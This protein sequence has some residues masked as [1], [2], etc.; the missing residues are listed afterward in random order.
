MIYAS[1]Y[2]KVRLGKNNDGGYV[3]ALLPGGY[4][5][6]LSGGISNDISFET[7]I[8][9][10]YPELT[11]VAFDGTIANIPIPEQLADRLTFVR[12]NLS[13]INSEQ[14]TNLDTYLAQYNNI[15]MK[16]D[17]EGGEYPLLNSIA[18]LANIKQL[19]IEF[20]NIKKSRA[21]MRRLSQ[22]HYLIHLHPNNSLDYK[23][24][25]G[26]KVPKVFEC[27]YVR[28][29]LFNIIPPPRNKETIPTN[30]DQPNHLRRPDIKLFK[31]PYV[32]KRAN[33][34]KK[35]GSTL[36]TSISSRRRK[37]K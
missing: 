4:D 17:I 6:F 15:F 23:F 32:K 31:W 29:D 26:I 13:N 34:T 37:K 18:N 7:A 8:L 27:T 28:K 10:L 1:P 9:E 19:V 20:H 3:V 12:K 24:I 25:Q 11:G 35:R 21:I 30:L 22:T 33:Y 14:T 16:L 36:R 2:P 5:L